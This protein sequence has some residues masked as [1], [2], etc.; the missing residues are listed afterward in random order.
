[1]RRVAAA[2]LIAL[3]LSGC[4]DVLAERQAFLSGLI[5]QSETDVVRIMGVP[6]RTF[7]VS[8][9]RFLAYD[10]RRLEVL[11][12]AP[13]ISPWGRRGPWGYASPF[14]SEV[15]SL[16]CETVLEFSAGRVIAFQLHGNACG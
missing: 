2:L 10:E 13:A 7:E 1:M 4:V 11:P 5:G 6:T 12:T 9:Q 8:V 16:S 14:P 3:L 15:V